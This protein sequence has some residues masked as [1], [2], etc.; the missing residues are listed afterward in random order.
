MYEFPL[1]AYTGTKYGETPKAPIQRHTFL[2]EDDDARLADKQTRCR[3]G[4]TTRS[5]QTPGEKKLLSYAKTLLY[6]V[7]AHLRTN[8]F[9]DPRTVAISRVFMTEDGGQRKA[10]DVFISTSHDI[11]GQNCS[12][13]IR[14]NVHNNNIR[15][16]MNQLPDPDT[17]SGYTV[18]DM[19][20]EYVARL[21]SIL[22]HELA[23]SFLAGMLITSDTTSDADLV[24][25]HGPIWTSVFSWLLTIATSE[26]GIACNTECQTC[27]RYGLCF[28]SQCPNCK[29]L[30]S[31]NPC[32]EPYDT[33]ATP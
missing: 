32:A 5:P 7:M 4:G 21:N 30:S 16:A 6:L 14:L 9:K 33:Y 17:R 24:G 10:S 12:G 23:H 20:A 2:T 18:N 8:H 25:V 11:A 27:Q 19:Q 28:P 31:E 22:L 15:D 26:L 1:Y 3:D 13:D 29:L